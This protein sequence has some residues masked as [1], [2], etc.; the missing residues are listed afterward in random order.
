MRCLAALLSITLIAGCSEPDPEQAAAQAEREIAMV[1][2]ANNAPPPVR[3]IVPEAIGGPEMM[4]LQLS[5]AGCN[6]APGTSLGAR[7]LAGPQDAWMKID[8]EM[9]RFAADA[10]AQQLAAGSW[11]RYLGAG[12]ELQLALEEDPSDDHYDGIIT[13][14]D[15]HGRVV[16]RGT[17][18][19]QCS[20]EGTA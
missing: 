10:G 6:Y 3:E 13:V 18:Y 2:Q 8:G 14:R 11:N 9:T 20:G 12:Y 4:R 19:A 16:Y 1:E 17:G 7:V 5:G 15:A